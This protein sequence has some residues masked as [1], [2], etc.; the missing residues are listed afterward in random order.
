MEELIRT[1]RVWQKLAHGCVIAKLPLC[2]LVAF[3]AF[4]ANLYAWQNV[5][6]QAVLIFLGVFLLASGCASLN[7]F[8]ERIHDGFLERTRKRPLVQKSVSTT[9]ALVQ[10]TFLLSFGLVI[11]LHFSNL[12]AFLAGIAGVIIYNF[13]YTLLKPKSIY[14]IVPGAIAGAVPPSI[15]WLAADGNIFS[16]EMILLILLLVFWQ[17][18]HFFLVLLKHQSDYAR[19][20]S[21]NILLSLSENSLKRIFLPWVT[22]FSLTMIAI[23]FGPHHIHSGSRVFIV[24]NALM[25]LWFFFFQ[26]FT[27]G[28]P[29][30][31]FLFH[32][33]NGSLL[34]FMI[35]VSF[36]VV[37]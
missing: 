22:A 26:M 5:Q 4:F 21:P 11:I 14:A 31:T 29:H 36:G 32:T 24:L 30:Y 37:Y 8:Q 12:N 15:G 27:S 17:I 33:L 28:K 18:P 1:G 2:S 13:V 7:S 34:L 35:T 10:A 3:S 25:L 6:A 9:H 23:G 16:Y 20:V 19:S